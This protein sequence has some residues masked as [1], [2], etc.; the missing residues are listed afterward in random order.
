M[1]VIYQSSQHY[2]EVRVR[3]ILAGYRT[4]TELPSSVLTLATALRRRGYQ[5]GMFGKWHLGLSEGLRPHDYGF[6]K[7]LGMRVS[8]FGEVIKWWSLDVVCRSLHSFH[9]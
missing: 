2:Q 9:R 7:W 3:S 8:C 6:D 1:M 4:A 5:S